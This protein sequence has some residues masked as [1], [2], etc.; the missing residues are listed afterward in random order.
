M[1]YY[2]YMFVLLCSIGLSCAIVSIAAAQEFSSDIVI[3][4]PIGNTSIPI[5]LGKI[6]TSG[7]GILG[8]L[9]LLAFIYG[10]V[11][12]LTSAGRE[13]MVKKGSHAMMYAAI[14]LLVIFSAYAI[15]S[16]IITGL[17]NNSGEGPATTTPNPGGGPASDCVE[18]F[19]AE[20][21]QCLP[22]QECAGLPEPATWQE[23]RNAASNICKVNRC[24]AT[25]N[26]VCCKPK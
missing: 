13:D 20:G 6:I 14:G 12:W 19:G 1:H 22:V 23:C 5:I 4:N 26:I 9:T 18:L 11:L 17:R 2:R 16:T 8:S 3:S 10:G 25:P 7:L 24:G 21:F 15:L